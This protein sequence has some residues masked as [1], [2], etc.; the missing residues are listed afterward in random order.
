MGTASLQEKP[1]LSRSAVGA[2]ALVVSL[3]LGIAAAFASPASAADDDDAAEVTVSCVRP[4][5]GGALECEVTSSRSL[6]SDENLQ[7]TV[8][9]PGGGTQTITTST[10]GTSGLRPAWCAQPS[11]DSL[12]CYTFSTPD[13]SADTPGTAPVATAG[14]GGDGGQGLLPAVVTAN[15]DNAVAGTYPCPSQPHLT[16][17]V[18]PQG[19]NVVTIQVHHP[20][21]GTGGTVT[22][23]KDD[24]STQH[25]A[26]G[27]HHSSEGVEQTNQWKDAVDETLD[28]DDLPVMW[29]ANGNDSSDETTDK[30]R[31]EQELWDRGEPYVVCFEETTYTKTNDDGTTETI[32]VP[33]APCVV[34]TPK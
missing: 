13:T 26:A 15:D 1:G 27:N 20:G 10:Q 17:I 14:D 7:L 16:C 8:E 28:D 12:H 29:A 33:P 4:E 31:L 21:T 25:D 3:S 11:S 30:I 9:V 32:T 34:I 5:G 6:S 22:I 18:Q 19:D 23:N 24:T 2:A